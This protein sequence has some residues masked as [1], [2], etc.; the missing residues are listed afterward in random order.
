MSA[1]THSSTTHNQ[2]TTEPVRYYEHASEVSSA[3]GSSFLSNS[4]NNSSLKKWILFLS[5]GFLLFLLFSIIYQAT[6]G[7]YLAS[8]AR[9]SRP[10]D[11]GTS[12]ESVQAFI[13]AHLPNR[14]GLWKQC[15][16]STGC[17]DLQLWCNRDEITDRLRS[18]GLLV[19][20]D[21]DQEKEFVD[22][23]AQ[24]CPMYIASRTVSILAFIFGVMTLVGLWLAFKHNSN[25]AYLTA[26]FGAFFAG[27]HF[28]VF[29][30]RW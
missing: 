8:N 1:T 24:L 20:A 13:N 22:Q 7:I 16:D 6:Q 27:M 9:T 21:A 17:I 4:F 10:L 19:K 29:P 5:M 18:A 12:E 30:Q 23:E 14:I 11:A 3:K 28:F 2:V 25:A 26:V 15:S